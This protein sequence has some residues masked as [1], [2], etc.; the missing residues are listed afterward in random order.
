MT[1]DCVKRYL[2]AM[3]RYPLLKPEEELEV[4]QKVKAGD[5]K[6]KELLLNSNLRLVVSIAKKYL[7]NNVPFEDLI[8]EGN[9]GMYRAAEKFDPD[10]GYKFST[11]AYWWIRQAVVRAVANQAR[12]VRIPI[13][14][15]EKWAEVKKAKRKLEA[16]LGRSPTT[17][18]ICEYL[19]LPREEFSSLAQHFLTEHSMQGFAGAS[20]EATL[21]SM[22]GYSSSDEDLIYQ[23]ELSDRLRSVAKGILTP[24]EYE[25]MFL[26]YELGANRKGSSIEEAAVR[27]N[28]PRKKARSL[29]A[30]AMRKM[31]HP[32]V[33][34]Q[35]KPL[36]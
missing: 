13:H 32:A 33:L 1:D 7:K 23:E 26:A 5:S 2:I 22:I 29:K 17:A 30:A 4:V 12:S 31:R 8:Q 19:E 25:I 28:L 9:L 6:A 35:L 3:G 10:L 16:Q 24:A 27:L 15:Q 11:Y 36:L 14:L 21:E 18:E 20:A 34:A